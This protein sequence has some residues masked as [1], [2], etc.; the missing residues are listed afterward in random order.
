MLNPLMSHAKK[1]NLKIAW[2][3]G[4]Q[5]LKQG[6]ASLRSIIRYVEVI[7][8]NKE[9][10]EQLTGMKAGHKTIDKQACPL[11]LMDDQPWISNVDEIMKT[12]HESGAKI[13]VITESRKGAQIYDGTWWYWMPIYPYAPIDTLGAGDAFG[14]TFVAGLIKGRTIADSVRLATANAGL[15]TTKIGAQPGLQTPEDLEK[16]IGKHSDIVPVRR[17]ME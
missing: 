1:Y 16:I 3:P 14:S 17:K 12:L 8:V 13:V 2:N 9:E 6:L 7:N 4:V 10:A 11:E 15:V 5:Q